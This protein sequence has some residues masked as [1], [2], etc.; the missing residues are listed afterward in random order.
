MPQ[1]VGKQSFKFNFEQAIDE[2]FEKVFLD[3]TSQS[4]SAGKVVQMVRHLPQSDSSLP[5]Q[6]TKR[7]EERTDS[8][9]CPRTPIHAL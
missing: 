9:G 5:T 2:N 8:T 3:F 6:A 7:S 1:L 4:E